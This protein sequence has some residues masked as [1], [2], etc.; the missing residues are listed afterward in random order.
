MTTPALFDVQTGERAGRTDRPSEDRILSTPS[1]DAVVVLDGVSTLSDDKP[2]GGWYAETLGR[3]LIDRLTTGAD[4]ELPEILHDA[5]AEITRAYGL[6]P[7]ASPAA[8]VSIVRVRGQQVE[9][10][11]LGDSPVV[12]IG[13]DGYED[14]HTDTRLATLVE[15]WPQAALYRRRLADGTGF[16]DQHRQLLRELRDEQMAW[17]N[18][19]GGYWVAEAVPEAGHQ[20]R[21]ASWPLADVAQILIAT[22]GVSSAVDDYRLYTWPKIAAACR[23]K[24]GPQAVVDDVHLIEQRDPNGRAFP[25]YKLSDDKVLAS[26]APVRSDE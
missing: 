1:G 25:R 5:I 26:L 19:P 10:A 24:G 6:S 7:G 8:T 16:D 2:R 14:V 20:A 17:I 13:H 23:T 21:T 9:A 22:D 4:A 11:V 12:V 3:L 15:S 18:E